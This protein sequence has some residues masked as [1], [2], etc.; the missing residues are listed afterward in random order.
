MTLLMVFLLGAVLYG[1]L[2]FGAWALAAGIRIRDQRES[3]LPKGG[4]RCSN[5]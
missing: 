1:A 5:F 4:V 2:A 3:L